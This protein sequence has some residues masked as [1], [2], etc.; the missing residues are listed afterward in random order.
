MSTPLLASPLFRKLERFEPWSAEE[1]QAMLDAVDGTMRL[2]AH[3]HVVQEDES[4]DGVHV[5]IEGFAC[6]YKLLPDGRRQIVSYCVPGDICDLRALLLRKLDCSI[7]TISPVQ[8]IR[9]TTQRLRE[10]TQQH[11]RVAR[12]LWRT[13]LVEQAIAREWVVNVGQRT[14]FSRA[15]HLLCEMFL[16]LRAVGL[17]QDNSCEFPLT[18][19]EIADTLALS[20]VHVNR[21][22]ME[23]RRSGLIT[24]RDK[25]LTIH[26][27]PGLEAAAGFNPGYLYLETTLDDEV[28]PDA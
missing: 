4:T 24:L 15:A 5:M 6:G 21:T 20:T 23:L 26:H 3:A 17:V 9:L 10:T 25:H 18:Q 13:T 2:P 11:P 19:T 16:R 8:L 28:T 22:L 27:L 1:R 7:G 12:A 14:A